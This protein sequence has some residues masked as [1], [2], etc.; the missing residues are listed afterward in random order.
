MPPPTAVAIEYSHSDICPQGSRY[1]TPAVSA[2]SRRR[3]TTM[4]SSGRDDMAPASPSGASG[5][6]WSNTE[7]LEAMFDPGLGM[8]FA[9][10]SLPSVRHA[11]SFASLGLFVSSP[12]P[13]A[14]AAPSPPASFSPRGNT[15]ESFSNPRP[16]SQPPR[17]RR[18]PRIGP[19]ERSRKSPSVC[20]VWA[21]VAHALPALVAAGSWRFRSRR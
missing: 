9:T 21:G 6:P 19:G 7:P 15:R 12:H 5:T 3:D 2:V 17:C 18:Y 10:A 4:V 13:R 16:V 20:F 8:S 1:A 11:Y 14:L